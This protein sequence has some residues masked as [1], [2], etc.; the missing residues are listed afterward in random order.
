M[1]AN[2]WTE[3]P[4]GTTPQ[5]S[6]R[7]RLPVVA[8]AVH[9]LDCL[10]RVGRLYFS[11]SPTGR[12]WRGWRGL[13]VLIATFAG[14]S[15]AIA[16]EASLLDSATSG[17]GSR[18][19]RESGHGSWTA[20]EAVFDTVPGRR[21]APTREMRGFRFLLL[22]CERSS[23]SVRCTLQVTSLTGDRTIRLCGQNQCGSDAVSV[24]FSGSGLDHRAKN[25]VLGSRSSRYA[26]SNELVGG[27]PINA[28]VEFNDVPTR[29]SALTVLR[30][31]FNDGDGGFYVP[32]AS[33][34]I[35]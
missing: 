18:D 7:L 6:A 17:L 12:S 33:I 35:R 13:G 34:F 20:A 8:V 26:I 3:T 1:V 16:G 32:F 15:T 31:A 10:A 14:V 29:A 30:I 22:G 9:R 21:A 5:S 23:A 19:A 27:E 4:L 25:A 2:P 24:A 28:T 11:K